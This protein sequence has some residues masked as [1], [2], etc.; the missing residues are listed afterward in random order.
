MLEL[1]IAVLFSASLLILGFI[2]LGISFSHKVPVDLVINTLSDIQTPEI[3]STLDLRCFG[4]VIAVVK[5]SD[6][7]TIKQ[8]EKMYKI[9]KIIYI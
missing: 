2:F 1:L 3:I 9:D 8:L 4:A 5:Q 7:K 6:E